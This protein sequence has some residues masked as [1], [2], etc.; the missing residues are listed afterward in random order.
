MLGICI[1]IDQRQIDWNKRVIL[2][3][4]LY[5]SIFYFPSEITFANY[6]CVRINLNIT[7]KLY[8]NLF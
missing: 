8:G 2:I 3:Q 5:L 7:F 1:E 4:K 6:Y